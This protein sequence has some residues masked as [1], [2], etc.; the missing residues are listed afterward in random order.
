MLG[1]YI[2]SDF[3]D[4]FTT[5]IGKGHE[6][7]EICSKLCV[8]AFICGHVSSAVL[9]FFLYTQCEIPHLHVYLRLSTM[10]KYT[11]GK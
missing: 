5:F 1:L 7:T 2:F 8:S 11:F 10:I 6:F 9:K 3:D 4:M